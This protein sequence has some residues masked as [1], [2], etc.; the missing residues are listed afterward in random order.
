MNKSGRS[1]LEFASIILVNSFSTP[2][3]VILVFQAQRTL[4]PCFSY[5][6]L[7]CSTSSIKSRSPVNRFFRAMYVCLP[8]E[9]PKTNTFLP[10]RHVLESSGLYLCQSQ[11]S[12]AHASLL[13]FSSCIQLL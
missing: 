11:P 9:S 4:P 2:P 6:R 13:Q 5:L 8:L 1:W 7:W 3:S 12:G 10:F